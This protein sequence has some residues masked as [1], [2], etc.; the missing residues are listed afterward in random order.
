MP[1]PSCVRLDGKYISSKQEPRVL[2]MLAWAHAA[3]T[4]I[5]EKLHA[6]GRLD[7]AGMQLSGPLSRRALGTGGHHVK[8]VNS[9]P[10]MVNL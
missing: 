8:F 7:V 2:P 10:R 4:E 6:P 1:F 9:L 3:L 5:F